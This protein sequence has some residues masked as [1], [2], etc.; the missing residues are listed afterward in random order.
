MPQ[1][2]GVVQKENVFMNSFDQSGDSIKTPVFHHVNL[3]TIRM[4]EMIE[5]YGKV[6][7]SR[8]QFQNDVMGFLTN[9]DVPGRI[10]LL[11]S[12]KL[13]DDPDRARH[14]GMHHSAW[15]YA[16]VDDLL[17]T[18]VRLKGEGIE[19]HM[20]LDHGFALSF[21]YVDPDGNSVE[22]QADWNNNCA[23]S[24]EFMERS[25]EFAANPVGR[26]V[27]PAKMVEARRGGMALP[28]LH[29]RAHQVGEFEPAVRPDMRMAL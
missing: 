9:D 12:S 1:Y 25:P 23:T 7:G 26:F 20:A 4:S 17:Q 10:A 29:H 13:A 5:W 24:C 21:Y 3:K 14:T 19:P 16:C 6:I 22:L 11:T 28:E 2:A 27:D 18:W 8:K 15:E